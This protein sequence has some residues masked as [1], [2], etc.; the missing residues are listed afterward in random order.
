MTVLTLALILCADCRAESCPIETGAPK[1]EWRRRSDDLDRAYLFIGGAQLGGIDR[2]R[3]EWRPYDAQRD[4]WGEPQPLFADEPLAC[5]SDASIL[6]FGVVR[7]PRLEHRSRHLLNGREVSENEAIAALAGDT[8]SDD[9]ERLRL[10]I[11]G[12]DEDRRRV[13]NDLANHEKFHDWAERLHVQA[14]RPEH[15]AVANTGF[16]T[17]GHPTIYL[18]SPNG[19]VLH[20]QDEYRGPERLVEALRRADPNYRP[21]RDP[22]LNKS[23]VTFNWRR[24]PVWGWFVAAVILLT[25]LRRN[26]S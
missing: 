10:T 1:I 25:I 5:F 6:N 7:N 26:K 23:F 4:A 12:S 15:W 17:G 22:D 11:I 19:H 20:R 16:V 9:S 3:L 8:L 2:E 24:V 14:Y 18:Q 21:E 13:L